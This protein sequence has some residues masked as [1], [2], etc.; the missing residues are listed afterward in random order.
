M[1]V[2]PQK[3]L[4]VAVV[5]SSLDTTGAFNALL[6]S[7]LDLREEIDFLFCLPANSKL[8]AVVQHA[9]L[10]V[11]PLPLVEISR[12]PKDLITYLP[13]LLR[14]AWRLRAAMRKH[15]ARVVHVNDL[16]NLMGI[17]TRWVSR[18]Q[19]RTVTHIR[20]M[21]ESLPARIYNFWV[22]LHLRYADLIVP[23]S[24]ANARAFG[25]ATQP[26]VRIVYDPLP[27]RERLPAYV[28][29]PGPSI[30]LLYLANYIPGK[31]QNHVIEA[32]DAL[33]RQAPKLAV[34]L[35]FVGG[36]FG[37]PGNLAWKAGLQ[38][39]VAELGIADQVVFEGKT[40]DSEA[41]MKAHDVVLNFSDSESFSRVSLEALLYGVPLIAT[42]VGGTREM[43]VAGETGLLVPAREVPAMTAAMHQLATD[44]EL[45]RRLSAASPDHVRAQFGR[46]ATSGR[47]LAVLREADVL[48]TTHSGR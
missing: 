48:A 12:R 3:R 45:R 40:D 29:R 38:A 36:D 5:E 41:T 31:G 17:A 25:G 19:V 13:Q 35:T 8:V 44:A 28:P 21:P 47:L 15:Q 6:Q 33:L 23:V 42:D 18:G 14:N 10:Q 9:G 46:S 34:T 1:T 20:R 16:H 43:F 2:R 27:S 24:A 37:F 26:K 30:S 4:S 7:V 11:Y 22:G 39:R 32:F